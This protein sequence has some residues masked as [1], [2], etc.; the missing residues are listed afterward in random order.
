MARFVKVPTFDIYDEE[1]G[2]WA[3]P[4]HWWLEGEMI[5]QS[6]LLGEDGKPVLVTVPD[7]FPTDLASIPRFPPLLRHIFLKNGRHRPAAIPHDFLC[8]R[9]Y[10]ADFRSPSEAFP[11]R[12]ADKIFLEA[13]KLVGVGR[14]KRRLMYWAVRA[15]TERLILMGKARKMR[16]SK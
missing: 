14:S 13:M 3:D 6:D 11:R 8:R 1:L 16:R 4:E 7:R 2:I 5:Y 9:S 12:L 10:V 15:N